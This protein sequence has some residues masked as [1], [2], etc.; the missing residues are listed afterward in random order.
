MDVVAVAV[1]RIWVVLISWGHNLGDWGN[2][3]D[4]WV[5]WVAVWGGNL[6]KAWVTCV[7]WISWGNSDSDSVGGGE[8]GSENYELFSEELKNFV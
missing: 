5:G 3:F 7:S 8:A 6:G 1:L 4:S 2:S